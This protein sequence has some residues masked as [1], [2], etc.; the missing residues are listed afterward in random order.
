VS[1]IGLVSKL[2]IIFVKKKELQEGQDFDLPAFQNDTLSCCGVFTLIDE[3][4][5]KS[6]EERRGGG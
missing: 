4:A 2:R 5:G 3:K 1:S 6:S